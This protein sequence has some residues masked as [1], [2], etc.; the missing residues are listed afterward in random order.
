MRNKNLRAQNKKKINLILSAVG[1]RMSSPCFRDE[2]D[3]FFDF[4]K[5]SDF[6][7]RFLLREMGDLGRRT[8]GKTI[9]NQGE[10]LEP[11]QDGDL[12]FLKV[13][14]GFI[15][16]YAPHD[17]NGVFARLY[18]TRDDED[19]T[20]AV[21]FDVLDPKRVE[22]LDKRDYLDSD[23]AFLRVEREGGITTI[24]LK[25]GEPRNPTRT[26][27]FDKRNVYLEE[28]EGDHSV[29][30]KYDFDGQIV[31]SLKTSTEILGYGVS[32][33]V[34]EIAVYRNG[35]S[36]CLTKIDEDDTPYPS[37]SRITRSFRG[38]PVTPFSASR[39]GVYKTGNFEHLAVTATIDEDDVV[40]FTYVFRKPDEGGVLE[41][42]ESEEGV[43]VKP[44]SWGV[45]VG[46]VE[47]AEILLEPPFCYEV[48]DRD[49]GEVYF[50]VN[51]EEGVNRLEKECEDNPAPFEEFHFPK[52]FNPNRSKNMTITQF[53]DILGQFVGFEE[54]NA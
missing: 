31:S 28:R 4:R 15:A 16:G 53:A 3:G 29:S 30:E 35:H 47:N 40:C 22:D 41:L 1:E 14:D 45:K 2:L 42:F 21:T 19:G 50:A 23:D 32:N 37:I 13:E 36:T 6:A 18:A 9:G 38:V 33:M 48:T 49:T 20:V 7:R 52:G 26:A 10:V 27:E 24:L 39:V 17:E 12:S 54:G 46:L 44:N 5:C 43:E 11:Y 34:T 25:D 51:I 8:D